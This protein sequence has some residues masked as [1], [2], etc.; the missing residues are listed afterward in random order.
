[1]GGYSSIRSCG[2]LTERTQDKKSITIMFV[3][4]GFAAFIVIG[5]SPVIIAKSLGKSTQMYHNPLNS[6]LLLLTALSTLYICFRYHHKE[7]ELLP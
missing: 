1:M 2:E 3:K 5:F 6:P 4:A 7:N